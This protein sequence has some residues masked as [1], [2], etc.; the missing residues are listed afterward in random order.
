MGDR[1]RVAAPADESVAAAV[2]RVPWE[3][4]KD[5]LHAAMQLTAEERSRFLDEACGSE[6]AL[7]AEI[8]SLLAADA[9]APSQFL[10][11]APA[12][13]GRTVQGNSE[14]PSAFAPGQIFE[15][16]F[17][18]IRILGEGGMGQV[19]LAEQLAPVRRPV[20]LKLIRAGFYDASV[21]QRFK[22]EQQ[23][24]A[25]MDHPCIAKVFDAGVTAQGQPYFVME[26]V[27]G[28]PIT[29]YCNQRQLDIAARLALFIR[30]CEGVQHAHQKAVIHRDLKPANILVVEIDGTPTPSII[31]FGLAKATTPLGNDATAQTRL[32]YF[33]GTPGY[34]SPEQFDLDGRDVDTRADVYALGV[35]LYELLTGC[36]PVDPV[37]GADVPFGDWLRTLRESEAPRPST[38]LSARRAASALPATKHDV[39]FKEWLDALRGDL[40]WIA[41]KA[42]E[43]DRTRRYQTPAEIAS[44]LN[45]HLKHEP[46]LARPASTGYRLRKYVR[47]HRVA[48]GVIVGLSVLLTG[49]SVMQA[50]E[51]RRTTQERDR[52]NLE[53][54]RA[55]LERDR[56]TRIADF[57][58]GMFSVSDPSESR[59]NAVTAREILDKAAQNMDHELAADSDIKSAMLHV[60]AVTYTN[61]GLYGR[62]HPLAQQAVDLRSKLH[63]PGD[64]GTLESLGQLG[65]I[66]DREGHAAEG[67]ALER[68]ALAGEIRNAGSNQQT[69]LET[70]EHLAVILEDE[71]RYAEAEALAR[72]VVATET[73]ELG[74]DS[75]QTLLA[76]SHLAFALVN[77][78][79][80]S[81]AEPLYRQLIEADRRVIGPDHPHTL[82][83]MVNLGVAVAAQGRTA[84][85][86]RIYRD[87]LTAQERVLGPEHQYTVNTMDALA[88]ILADE[89]RLSE[90]EALHRRELGIRQRT[91]GPEHP[92]ALIAMSNLADV[93]AREGSFRES[94]RW[95]RQSVDGLARALG[96]VNPQ[97]LESQSALAGILVR[98]GRYAA[99]EAIA[100]PTF[101]AQLKSLGPDHSD[102]LDTLRRL[103]RSLAYSHRYAEASELFRGVIAQQNDSPNSVNRWEAWYGFACVAIAANRPD[104][105]LQYLREAV[106]RGFNGADGLMADE[107]LKELRH[108]PRFRELVAKIGATAGRGTDGTED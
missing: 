5:L 8:E 64:T 37:R 107:E 1:T 4:V 36:K 59:G 95:Q 87:A 32:G 72:R 73:R 100:A 89:G 82:S 62:A 94:E 68:R 50:L 86:E 55:N 83:A 76:T 102:T 10:P 16:R 106:D 58:T 33:L 98:E 21:V 97:T 49:F 52:A 20:A 75:A 35:I 19:W 99:A 70:M 108:S 63:G 48:A 65:W 54:D 67:E 30:V 90:A 78:A 104:D 53:R 17:Q 46:V 38:Q 101:R 29:A 91:L 34:M 24:L 3:R 31:D 84:E 28:A 93:L 9:D 22:S 26:F 41:L 7:R 27:P 12:A 105:A 96:P 79:R 43:R 25:I 92:D 61:L 85:A 80:Y 2:N 88:N 44:D 74:P 40:D 57:M 45:R 103:G 77:Q 81:D 69:A 42:L 66:M 13:P 71:G 18:L 51:L 15:G 6:V 56:A 11:S 60:M 47:R 14:E 39:A 23:S